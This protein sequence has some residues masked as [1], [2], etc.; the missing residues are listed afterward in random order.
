MDNAIQNMLNEV[1]A[2]R[3]ENDRLR[4]ENARL[5]REQEAWLAEKEAMAKEASQVGEARTRRMQ[6][7]LVGIRDRAAHA[8]M[9]ESVA[10]EDIYSGLEG[11]NLRLDD[12][13]GGKDARPSQEKGPQPGQDPE[14]VKQA[15]KSAAED[16]QGK[17]PRKE[18]HGSGSKPQQTEET[19][20]SVLPLPGRYL[21]VACTVPRKGPRPDVDQVLVGCV[22]QHLAC[23]THFPGFALAAR[24][25]RLREQGVLDP[26]PRQVLTDQKDP[27]PDAPIV[28]VPEF[29]S[30]L[31]CFICSKARLGWRGKSKGIVTRWAKLYRQEF[32]LPAQRRKRQRT[33]SEEDRPPATGPTEAMEATGPEEPKEAAE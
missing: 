15:G 12:I 25:M 28:P 23:R 13:L 6:D 16:G 18:E 9:A 21:C 19:D 22:D 3:E 30:P 29:G 26:T 27:A 2:L 20:P 24:E 10:V 11:V 8:L 31:P 32:N 1:Q 17:R 4:V 33:D 7:A 14:P 5:L